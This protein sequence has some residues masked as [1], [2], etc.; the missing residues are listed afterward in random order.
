MFRARVLRA[1]NKTCAVCTLKYPELLDAAHIISDSDERGIP[2]VTNGMAMCKIHDTACGHDF[3][4]VSP[5]CV[6]H[7][8]EKLLADRDGPMLQFGLQAMNGKALELPSRRDNRP[9]R[10]YLAERFARFVA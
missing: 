6:V 9:E 5:D 4:G 10:D 1:Y 7:I 3:L 2:V 8:N